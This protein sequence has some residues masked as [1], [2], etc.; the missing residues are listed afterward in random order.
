MYL[1]IGSIVKLKNDNKLYM[2]LGYYSLEYHN[3]INIY[4]YVACSY[5]E[6]LLIKNNMISFNH[7]DISTTIFIGYETDAFVKLKN[8]LENEE[9]TVLEEVPVSD[10]PLFTIME[11]KKEEFIMPHYHFDE[12]GI[13]IEEEAK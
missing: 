1:P 10:E 12:N 6:G 9:E 4:D 11:E 13:I 3:G 5:P 7:E 8:S 2:I